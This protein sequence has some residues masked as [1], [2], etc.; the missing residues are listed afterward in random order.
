[1]NPEVKIIL[2]SDL[3]DIINHENKYWNVYCR[4]AEIEVLFV[5]K[6]SGDG[7]CL[8]LKATME[9]QVLVGAAA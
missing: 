8:N 3:H 9:A 6:S 4:K 5:D 1:M 7:D 2:G